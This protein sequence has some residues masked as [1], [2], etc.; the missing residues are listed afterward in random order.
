MIKINNDPVSL[1]NIA[2]KYASIVKEHIQ[3]KGHGSNNARIKKALSSVP[4]LY[5]RLWHIVENAYK[6]RGVSAEYNKKIE[7]D[8]I[9]IYN[10][11]PIRGNQNDFLDLICKTYFNYDTNMEIILCENNK[12]LSYWIMD[13]LEIKTCPYCNRLY[14]TTIDLNNDNKTRPELD[15]FYNK[16]TNRY[17]SSSFYNLVPSCSVCNY[18][19][20][21]QNIGINP[22][23]EDFGNNCKFTIDWINNCI[24]KD[25]D[26]WDLELKVQNLDPK[27]ECRIET[28]IAILGLNDLYR[29]HRDVASEIAW[30]AISYQE[31]YFRDIEETFTQQM[32]KGHDFK[33]LVFGCPIDEEKLGDRP[34]SKLTRDLLEQI[35]VDL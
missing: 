9:D 5:D 10:K 26:D 19:K 3:K 25:N 13:S 15:H 11:K 33:T 8:L 27:K 6:E 7:A 12:K 35:G 20:G 32:L 28:N 30:K 1:D 16:S 34:L 23:F 29:H 14:T 2:R 22:Y 24:L 21:I 17:L 18:L 4:Q 31:P